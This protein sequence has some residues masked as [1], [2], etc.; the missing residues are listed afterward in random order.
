M[1]ILPLARLH[2]LNPFGC[3]KVH[4]CQSILQN[5]APTCCP[6]MSAPL[7]GGAGILSGSVTSF[8]VWTSPMDCN[9]HLLFLSYICC[10]ALFGELQWG[11]AFELAGSIEEQQKTLQVCE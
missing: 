3:G 9:A 11:V 2:M 4:L 10:P 8:D 7:G 6:A 1:C 5:T